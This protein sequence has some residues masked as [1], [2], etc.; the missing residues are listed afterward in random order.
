MKL[1]I[2]SL[3]IIATL[4]LTACS[5]T[6]QETNSA[7]STE[8][9]TNAAEVSNTNDSVANATASDATVSPETN[10]TNVATATAP[11]TNAET[12]NT[13]FAYVAQGNE[14]DWS[15]NVQANNILVFSTP[16]NSDGIKLNAE[17]SAY[18]KGV[19]YTGNHEGKQFHLNL[20]GDQ[21][22]DTMSGQKYDMTAVFE[23]NGVKYSGCAKKD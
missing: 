10:D 16:D 21:C 17:R 9:Q 5:Q 13:G 14:P 11:A 20:K 19:E 22:E 6:K 3:T 15:I 2:I 8:N 18:A 1:N 23:F 7:E 12:E 4:A